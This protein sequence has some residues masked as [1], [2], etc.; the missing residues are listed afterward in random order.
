MG[1]FGFHVVDLK[2]YPHK[3]IMLTDKQIH[4]AKPRTTLYRLLD[5]EGL[6]LELAPAGGKLWRF[7]YHFGG[8]HQ[9]VAIADTTYR[10]RTLGQALTDEGRRRR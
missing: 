3:D 6:Y 10:C 1:R 7:R 9:T 5:G 4:N 2:I 8:G